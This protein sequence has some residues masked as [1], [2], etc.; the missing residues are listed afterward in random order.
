M[1]SIHFKLII[2]FFTSSYFLMTQQNDDWGS[3]LTLEIMKKITSDFSV[4][5]EGEHRSR[6]NFTENERWN[7]DSYLRYDLCKY[8]TIGGGFT[9]IY[10]S[11][12]TKGWENRYRW[13]AHITGEYP[14]G[15]FKFFLRER[16]QSTEREGVSEYNK[17]N[18]RVRANPK[19]VLRSRLEVEYDVPKSHFEPFVSVE[20]FHKLNHPDENGLDKVR[21]SIGTT[22]KIT[23]SHSITAFF[24]Y[25]NSQDIDEDDCAKILSLGYKFKF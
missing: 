15:D 7:I 2:L 17:K 18:E 5:L 6:A 9:Y 14:I 23:K 22:Y 12:L 3:M 8:V 1:K 20:F 11:H 19:F 13:L 4:G 10:Y 24:R 25:I 16:F 21:Y